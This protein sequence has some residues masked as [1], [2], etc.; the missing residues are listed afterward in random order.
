MRMKGV[1]PDCPN[2]F[3]QKFTHSIIEFLESLLLMGYSLTHKSFNVGTCSIFLMVPVLCPLLITS[4]VMQSLSLTI[5]IAFFL[6]ERGLL[7]RTGS[8]VSPSWNSLVNFFCIS[9]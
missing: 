3:C 8:R 2:L 9:R 7:L 6:R 5:E 4:R 1:S